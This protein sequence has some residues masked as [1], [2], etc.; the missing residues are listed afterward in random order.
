MF[1]SIWMVL[2]FAMTQAAAIAADAAPAAPDVVFLKDGSK[3]AGR[4]ASMTGGVMW[5]ETGF[6][7]TLQIK[8]EAVQGIT[9]TRKLLFALPGGERVA[10][11]PSYDAAS[12]QKLTNTSFGD[13]TL[14][15]AKIDAVWSAH[16]PA[17]IPAGANAQIAAVQQ[18]YEKKMEAAKAEHAKELAAAKAENAKLAKPWSTRLEIGLTGTTGNNENI[19]FRGRAETKRITPDDR[20]YLY[21]E[22][23][24]ASKN[25]ER[26]KNEI[27]GGVKFEVD[28][29]K[30][31]FAYGKLELEYDEFENLDLRSTATGGLGLFLIRKDEQELKVRAGAGYQHEAFDDGTNT[32]NAVLEA[33]YDYRIDINKW[34]RFT[35]SLTYYPILDDPMKNYRLDIVTGVEVPLGKDENWKLKAGV[36]NEYNAEPRPGIDRLDTSYFLNL[37]Y[38]LP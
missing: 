26:S 19:S 11:T 32:D 2:F 24:Y 6:A 7:G 16:S 12:G 37:V 4:I 1:K 3:L 18:E 5:L 8:A 31:L 30:M 34:L 21:I 10:G 33:G 27:F 23:N 9:S 25:G 36:H 20:T 22:G 17:P 13:V 14:K 35:H 38:D 28:I 29:T 15:D